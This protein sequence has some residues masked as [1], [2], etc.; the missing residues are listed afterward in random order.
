[1]LTEREGNERRC[2]VNKFTLRNR[3]L[4]QPLFHEPAIRPESVWEG[5]KIVGITLDRKEVDGCRSPFRDVAKPSQ[6]V[7]T[8]RVG[9]V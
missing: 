4:D 2:L 8:V 9:A 5:G 1:M 3:A 7:F 6:R